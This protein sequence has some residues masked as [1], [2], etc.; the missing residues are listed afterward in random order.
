MK[1]RT[2]KGK[3]IID[4][5]EEYVCIDIETTGL[6]YEYDNIIEISAAH[7]ISGSII[8]TFSSLAQPDNFTHLPHFIEELTGITTEM[9]LSAPPMKDVISKLFEVIGD[10]VLVGHNVNFDVNFIYDSAEKYGLCLSNDFIDTLR[11]SRRLFPDM[12]NH[13][14][15]DL[16]N[17]LEIPQNMSHRSLPDVNTTVQCYESMK[18]IISE[19]CG[20]DE[21]VIWFKQIKQRKSEKY[22]N[23]LRDVV[24]TS[25]F[26]D[27]TNPI[28][29]KVIVFTGSLS[30]MTRKEAFQIVANLG[31]IPEDRITRK[32]NFLVI[33]SEDFAKSVKNGKTS[34]MKK[35]EEY[36]SAGIDISTISE[37]SFFNM[38]DDYIK[39][40]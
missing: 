7:V 30:A 8:K 12:K 34:K 17:R 26:I 21:F 35:A 14:L 19:T 38:I 1:N 23:S 13:R 9:I 28:Y 3:S 2:N 22:S 32:T 29:G 4:F 36:L 31:G 33:G 15:S 20:I 25:D 27:Q 40:Q 5:P 11:I 24:S 16:S 6:D 39:F 18:K 37:D 10:Y